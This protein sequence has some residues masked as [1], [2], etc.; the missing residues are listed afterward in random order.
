MV[1][2][3]SSYCMMLG[4]FGLLRSVAFI[5]FPLCSSNGFREEVSGTLFYPLTF[6]ERSRLLLTFREIPANGQL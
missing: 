5:G 4:V 3:S 6:R 2:G 1:S